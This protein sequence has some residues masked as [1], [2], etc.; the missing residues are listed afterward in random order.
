[1]PWEEIDAWRLEL[2]KGRHID[3]GKAVARVLERPIDDQ[4]VLMFWILY[5]A[6]TYLKLVHD[7]GMSRA[8]YVEFLVDASTRLADV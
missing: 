6:E 3:V 2:E 4:L 7:S 1:M 8:E 5:S